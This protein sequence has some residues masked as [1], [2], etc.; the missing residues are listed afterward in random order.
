[1]NNYQLISQIL[2]GAWAVNPVWANAQVPFLVSL[3]D[4]KQQDARQINVAGQP[5]SFVDRT[6]NQGV[7]M[8]FV[9]D[10]NTGERVQLKVYDPRSGSYVNNPNLPKAAV[11][12]IPISSAITKYNVECGAP[13]MIQRDGW[14][15]DFL[16][17]DAIASV[18]LLMD[19]PGG[20]VRAADTFTQ[21][22]QNSSKPIITYIDGMCCSLGMWFASATD[23]TFFASKN[24]ELGSIGALVHFADMSG[25][26]EKAGIELHEIYARQSKDKNKDIRD[27]KKG[28]YTQ[29]EDELTEL[30]SEF[31]DHIKAGRPAAAK[32][33][34]KWN[35]GKV[36]RADEAVKLGLADGILPFDRVVSYSKFLARTKNTTK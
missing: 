16:K 18:I 19:T 26:L 5:M 34:D 35:T 31:I 9:V 14:L 6:G 22:I 29:I 33:A 30:V 20:E 2:Y 7:E 4:G 11:G 8:P 13:G 21:T 32:S 23:K 36:F 27:A 12:V 24:G 3:L 1:M 10:P 25:M 17:N 28:N 15:R